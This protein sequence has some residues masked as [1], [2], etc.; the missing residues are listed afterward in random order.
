MQEVAAYSTLA[1]TLSLVVVRPRLGSVLRIT[2][3]G[4][5]M[6]GVVVMAM[7]G[8]VGIASVRAAVGDVW[9]SFVAIA[10][11]MVMTSVALDLGVL[12]WLSRQVEAR[13]STTPQLFRLVFVLATATASILNN[14]AAI[15][16]LTPLVVALV[17]RRYP[18]RPE[19]IVPF[20]F[21]VFMAAGVAPFMVSNPMNM[22]VAQYAGIGFN[23]YAFH[24]VPIALA[25]WV[26]AYATLARV[27]RAQLATPL[28]PSA[29]ERTPTTP[30]QRL[31]IGLLL[32]VLGCYSVIGYV[33]GP[34]WLVALGGA[35]AALLIAQRDRQADP[36]RTIIEGVSWET[37]LF[38]LA[39][40]ILAMGLMNVGLVD[41]LTAHYVG[42]SDAS[43]GV[44]SALGSAL[45]NNHPMAYM[46]MLALDSG[47][48]D[49]SAVLA[50]LIGGDLGPRLLPMG[51]LAGLLW[52]E[53]L[54]RAGVTIRLRT[55]VGL[56]LL[57]TIPTLLISLALLGLY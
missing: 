48:H 50:A 43:V 5:A 49:S 30:G 7:L 12:T 51:S 13:A 15:L 16:L 20:A 45:L 24:M 17:R 25:G 1:M 53:S 3:A 6:A 41:H 52:I 55:F 10:S 57:V 26:I 23:E 8:I 11:I 27:F 4:A 2:P 54:R 28:A 19:L 39:V 42:G 47:G 18:D 32:A 22:V 40:L 21:A 29:D 56:G 35:A 9:S 34:V 33:G 37:L 14:D 44:T 36:V 46:N 31:M 38:L